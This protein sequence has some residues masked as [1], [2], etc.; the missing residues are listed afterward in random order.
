MSKPK[1]EYYV[2]DGDEIDGPWRSFGDALQL[3]QRHRRMDAPGDKA[4]GSVLILEVTRST[5]ISF[6]RAGDII[7]VTEDQS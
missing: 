7:G 4:K 6:N 1:T 2:L 3:E 5:E